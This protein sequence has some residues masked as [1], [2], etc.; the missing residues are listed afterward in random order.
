MTKYKIVIEYDGSNY[1]GWQRQDNG[2]SIQGSIE[3][4]VKKLTE[5]GAAA[6]PALNRATRRKSPESSMRAFD[7][8]VRQ[9][10]DGDE[11][12]KKK[13]TSALKKIAKSESSHSAKAKKALEPLK[14]APGTANKVTAKAD[15][16]IGGNAGINRRVSV[17]TVS[18][19]STQKKTDKRLKLIRILRKESQSKSLRTK[20]VKK[21]PISTRLLTL[22]SSRKSIPKLMSCIRNILVTLN[23]VTVM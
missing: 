23:L 13:A 16:K 10:K 4:A 9:Y 1:V 7:I 6:I 17:R 20:K 18:L 21:R 5:L 19:Q 22:R 12:T 8:I 3:Q 14:N 11:A 2:L 15:I